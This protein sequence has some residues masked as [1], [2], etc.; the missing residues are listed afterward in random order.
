MTSPLPALP[1]TPLKKQLKTDLHLPLKNVEDL[2]RL[3]NVINPA[4]EEFNEEIR[5]NLVKKNSE[6][7]KMMYLS[8]FN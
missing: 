8:M 3:S 4:G 6:I 2:E 1:T 7:L 5:K